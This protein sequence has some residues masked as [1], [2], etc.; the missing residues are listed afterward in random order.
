M[1]AI[2]RIFKQRIKEYEKSKKGLLS[3]IQEEYMDGE[4]RAVLHLN[5]TGAE[6]YNP[7]SMN[8]QQELSGEIFDYLDSKS[9]PVPAEI[10]LIIRIHGVEPQERA[11]VM[12]MIREH[13]DL[14]THDKRLDLRL[15][16]WRAVFMFALGIIMLSLYFFLAFLETEPILYEVLS[17]A[18]NFIVWEAVDFALL[19]RHS[20]KIAY[21]DSVQMAMAEIEFQ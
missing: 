1:A 13:Y 3:Y 21:H 17:I 20:L 7:L 2:R 19:E 15:N 14:Q 12:S 8:E 16:M 4:G 11:K 10:P 5:L 9:Y 6:L 18:A